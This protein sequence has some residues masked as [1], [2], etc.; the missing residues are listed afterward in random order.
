QG[1][2][3]LADRR[4]CDGFS[5][6]VA[7]KVFSPE[8]YADVSAYDEDMTRVA[9][10]AARVAR[11]QHDN[12]PCVLDFSAVG[13]VR[14][15]EMEW[16]DGYDLRRVLSP[17]M[18]EETRRRVSPERLRHIDDIIITPGPEQPRLKPGVAIAVLRDCLAGL[19]ALHRD[20]LVHGD[21]KPAN[22]LLCRAGNAKLI[23]IGSA[24]DPAARPAPL[25]W[26]PAYAGP[27]V[28]GGGANTPRSDL[29]SLGYVL[30]ELL[31]GRRPFEGLDSYAALVEAKRGLEGRLAA[32]LPPQVGRDERLLHLCRR[33]VAADPSRRFA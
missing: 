22:V 12:L 19:A 14:L 8:P 11:V 15:M 28:L 32:L 18:L 6:P 10:V 9:A 4:G 2:V 13:G 7:L 30:V 33:L 1:A 20:G 23:D 25:L 26:A 27:E 21:L 29:A 3:Y 31:A 5:R 16:L 17:A 24:I